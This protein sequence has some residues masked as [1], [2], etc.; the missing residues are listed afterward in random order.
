MRRAHLRFRR[1]FPRLNRSGPARKQPFLRVAE[2]PQVQPGGFDL[3][4][5][6]P[7]IGPLP[8]TPLR[9]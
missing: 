7:I 3:T 6:L 9:S 2:T 8:L 1:Q 4:H 5:N